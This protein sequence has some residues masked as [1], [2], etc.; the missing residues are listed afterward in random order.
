[1]RL[2]KTK[3]D[4]KPTDWF[5]YSRYLQK[6]VGNLHNPVSS[7][8]FGHLQHKKWLLPTTGFPQTQDLCTLSPKMLGCRFELCFPETLPHLALLRVVHIITIALPL[9]FRVF[10]QSNVAE[11]LYAKDC[12]N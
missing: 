4:Y 6:A 2:K 12:F 9:H 3:P 5:L 1:M 7:V 11:S 10:L 8:L